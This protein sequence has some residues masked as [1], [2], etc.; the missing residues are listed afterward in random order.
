METTP[1]EL[2]AQRQLTGGC[3]CHILIFF[4]PPSRALPYCAISQLRCRRTI[5]SKIELT[6]ESFQMVRLVSTTVVTLSDLG[7]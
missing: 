2:E 1:E 6:T 4:P 5:P 3:G 7:A